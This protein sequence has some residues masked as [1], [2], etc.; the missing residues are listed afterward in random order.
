MKF[1]AKTETEIKD[2]VTS[3]HKI[4]LNPYIC[5]WVFLFFFFFPHLTFICTQAEKSNLLV[6]KMFRD[7]EKKD[8]RSWCRIHAG[9]FKKD[10][11]TSIQKEMATHSS[12][13]V[14]RIPGTEEPGGPPPMG[15]HRVRHD[16][17]HLAAAAAFTFFKA[18]ITKEYCTL[19]KA[20]IILKAE[21]KLFL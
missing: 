7:L 16:W 9:V 18:Y 13:L 8:C 1:K 19:A 5:I 4:R 21:W 10:F 6:G 15:S 17:S 12:I 20:Q 2:K 14:W 3:H 11:L